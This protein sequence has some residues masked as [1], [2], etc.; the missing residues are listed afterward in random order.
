[1]KIEI[2]KNF[3]PFKK[4][5]ILEVHKFDEPHA[6]TNY[7]VKC[8]I[9]CGL[10]AGK[11]CFTSLD[12]IKGLTWGKLIDVK[13]DEHY[14]TCAIEPWVIMENN[15]TKEEFVG[16]LKGN[17]VK[18]VNRI[19]RKGQDLDDCDKIANYAQKLKEVLQK[20]IVQE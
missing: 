19:G 9:D 4:G 8:D 16:F 5:Q 18:Y 12:E 15:F 10:I 11:W 2:T 7:W 6:G 3:S 14:K 17:I 20:D 1:M 13:H